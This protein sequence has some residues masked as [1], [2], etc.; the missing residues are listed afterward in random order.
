VHLKNLVQE[1]LKIP[2]FLPVA[3]MAQE[4][5]NIFNIYIFVVGIKICSKNS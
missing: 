3:G 5:Q 4:K 2:A 1:F